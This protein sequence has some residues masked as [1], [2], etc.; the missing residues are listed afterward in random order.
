VKQAAEPK[1]PPLVL[2]AKN[3]AAPERDAAQQQQSG[4][5]KGLFY[6]FGGTIA[7]FALTPCEKNV[8]K[9]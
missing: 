7:A 8:Q 9:I 2:R 5:A 3:R 6:E 4:R 1:A